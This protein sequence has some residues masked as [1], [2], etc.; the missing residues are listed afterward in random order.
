MRYRLFIKQCV[1]LAGYGTDVEDTRE[2]MISIQ[3]SHDDLTLIRAT[4]KALRSLHSNT[5]IV[6]YDTVAGKRVIG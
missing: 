4:T 6:I 3:F 1:Q 2:Q 5:D